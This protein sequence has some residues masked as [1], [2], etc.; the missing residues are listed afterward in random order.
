MQL[1]N[2]FHPLIVVAYIYFI[3]FNIILVLDIIIKLNFFYYLFF[4]TKR[5]DILYGYFVLTIL[6]NY[7]QKGID[8]NWAAALEHNPEA[9]ARV[10]CI[11][12]LSSTPAITITYIHTYIYIYIYFFVLILKFLMQLFRLC[13]TWTWR[14]MVS[15]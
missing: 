14:L 7:L 9:F 8:E 6:L 2:F 4:H 12:Y 10:V 1:W 11:I 3:F 13:C 5:E 15:H